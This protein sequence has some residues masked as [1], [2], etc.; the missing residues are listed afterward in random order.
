MMAVKRSI[1]H[2]EGVYFITFTCYNW[3]PLIDISNSYDSFYTWFD[4]LKQQGHYIIG[5]QI[6]PNH[7][8][9]VIA[10]RNVNKDINKIVGNGKRFIAYE[11]V[12]NLIKKGQ[13]D[14]LRQL[15]QAVTSSDKIKGKLHE[16]WED[17]FDWK[18]CHSRKMI[19]QKLNYMHLNPCRGKWNLVE[20]PID[21]MHS[22]AKYYITGEQGRYAVTNYMELEDIDLTSGKKNDGMG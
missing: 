14:L 9:V 2:N 16:V 5:Y 7:V 19:I 1:P 10:F 18:E 21:Y 6:M 3:L 20:N 11:V 17:S 12:A 4:Y 8:H 22:S 13:S 15:E